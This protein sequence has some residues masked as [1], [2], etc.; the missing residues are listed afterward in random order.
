VEALRETQL[1]RLPFDL[2]DPTNQDALP[3]EYRFEGLD[4]HRRRALTAAVACI[5]TARLNR[6]ASFPPPTLMTNACELLRAAL[7]ADQTA[8]DAVVSDAVAAGAALADE[9]HKQ[10][11]L[12]GS[13]RLSV[14]EQQ[15]QT[16]VLSELGAQPR[17]SATLRLSKMRAVNVVPHGG[18]QVGERIDLCLVARALGPEVDP[19]SAVVATASAR[20]DTSTGEVSFGE[21]GELLILQ[22]DAEP[23]VIQFEFAFAGAD[24]ADMA[25]PRLGKAAKPM[26]W[27]P[28][29]QTKRTT[30]QIELDLKTADVASATKKAAVA[31]THGKA[32]LFGMAK[33]GA[34]A[35]RA[36]A[37]QMRRGSVELQFADDG[38]QK[39]VLDA[40][41]TQVAPGK[42]REEMI[43]AMLETRA[44]HG[45]VA[46]SQFMELC[47]ELEQQ[48]DCN[49]LE[50]WEQTL[51]ESTP[52]ASLVFDYSFDFLKLDAPAV[53][54]KN[55]RGDCAPDTGRW[56]FYD[57]NLLVFRALAHHLLPCNFHIT[58]QDSSALE[59][60][61]RAELNRLATML[62]LGEELLDDV[63]QSFSGNLA[64]SLRHLKQAEHE[65]AKRLR[66]ESDQIV[67][68]STL[69]AT[70]SDSD[71]LA[72]DHLAATNQIDAVDWLLEDFSLKYGVPVTYRKLTELLELVA[73]F[74]VSVPFL[75]RLKSTLQM[76][77]ANAD[78]LLPA[79]TKLL[80]AIKAHVSSSLL[81][82]LRSYQAFFDHK[83]PD[84]AALVA[85]TVSVLKKTAE[86][87]KWEQQLL[88]ALAQ[89]PLRL[90]HAMVT[91]GGQ[92]L[93]TLSADGLHWTP[94][95][96][97]LSAEKLTRICEAVQQD[98]E[99]N[100][101]EYRFLFEEQ[102]APIVEQSVKQ[103]AKCV[104]QL[105][106][107]F[108]D[109]A[110]S[111]EALLRSE[112]SMQLYMRMNNLLIFMREV[113]PSAAQDLAEMDTDLLF[114]SM[115]MGQI[116]QE[117]ALTQ[118]MCDR[119]IE[120]DNWEPLETSSYTVVAE[121][122]LHANFQ[123]T[124][125]AAKFSAPAWSKLP[126][127]HSGTLEKKGARDKDGYKSRWF[128]LR[129]HHLV[130]Y[131]GSEKQSIKGNINLLNA[132]AVEE[133]SNAENEL[134]IVMGDAVGR[135]FNLRADDPGTRDEWVSAVSSAWN[136]ASREL[137]QQ[138]S[139][140]QD[141]GVVPSGT[142]V[143][144]E[145]TRVDKYG[146]NH[147]RCASPW[148][149][150]LNVTALDGNRLLDPIPR[151]DGPFH[152]Q[153]AHDL[154]FMMVQRVHPLVARW[155]LPKVA[156]LVCQII[157]HYCGRMEE[158]CNAELT[159]LIGTHGRSEY[160]PQP[161]QTTG[162]ARFKTVA[163]VSAKVKKVKS[164][165]VLQPPS[166]WWV[167]LSNIHYLIDKG[168]MAFCEGIQG[169][170]DLMGAEEFEVFQEA[171]LVCREPC[172]HNLGHPLD[173][174]VD[175]HSDTMSTIITATL[176]GIPAIEPEQWWSG[177]LCF[178]DDVLDT[179][180][181]RTDEL[182]FRR[183]LRRCGDGFSRALEAVLVG[184]TPVS[185]V[186][187]LSDKLDLLQRCLQD[188]AEFFHAGGQGLSDH[189][190]DQKMSLHS[191]LG[192]LVSYHA[193]DNMMLIA[194]VQ[195]WSGHTLNEQEG[196]N[197]RLALL[198]LGTREAD[199][200]V[201]QFLAAE[202]QREREHSQTEEENRASGQ[203]ATP[204][205]KQLKLLWG[206]Q[207]NLEESVNTAR[208]ELAGSESQEVSSGFDAAA[209]QSA[210]SHLLPCLKAYLEGDDPLV[211]V[212][213]IARASGTDDLAPEEHVRQAAYTAMLTAIISSALRPRAGIHV[214][215]KNATVRDG[216]EKTS[217]E[218]GKLKKGQVIEVEEMHEQADGSVRAAYDVAGD[219]CW[220][221]A[222]KEDGQV[223]L[224]RVAP[225]ELTKADCTLL[226]RSL[227]SGRM[228]DKR[229][230]TLSR[231]MSVGTPDTDATPTPRL[232]SSNTVSVLATMVGIDPPI[233]VMWYVNVTDQAADPDDMWS[234]FT[235]T[236]CQK[237]ERAFNAKAKGLS[238]EGGTVRFQRSGEMTY[239]LKT[240]NLT[241]KHAKFDVA[242]WSKLPLL[243]SGTLEK[244]GARDK[245]GYKSRWF[246]LRGHHLVYYEDSESDKRNPKG[247]INLL[248]AAA[249][250]ESADT[251]NELHIVMGDAGG[252]TYRLKADSSDT[253]D[254]WVSAVSSA[255][256]DAVEE[257]QAL[258]ERALKRVSFVLPGM[259]SEGAEQRDWLQ[260][261][262]FMEATLASA[263]RVQHLEEQLHRLSTDRDPLYHKGSFPECVYEDWK[264]REMLRLDDQMSRLK[265][266]TA[267][268]PFC[269]R[270]AVRM[271][272]A[273][274]LK[275]KGGWPRDAFLTCRVVVHTPGARDGD[276]QVLETQARK[277]D[278]Q[279]GALAWQNEELAFT[280]TAEPMGIALEVYSVPGEMKQ[281]RR[282]S[283]TMA[284]PAGRQRSVTMAAPA[285]AGRPAGEGGGGAVGQQLVASV[286]LDLQQLAWCPYPH[287]RD[288]EVGMPCKNWQSL[289]S[290][291]QNPSVALLR[292]AL[293]YSFTRVN[294]VRHSVSLAR[295]ESH[296]AREI[297]CGQ[298]LDVAVEGMV[299][300]INPHEPGERAALRWLVEE[301]G[302]MTGLTLA[303][304]AVTRLN[305][306]MPH[307]TLNHLWLADVADAMEVLAANR[308][309]MLIAESELVEPIVEQL[310]DLVSTMFATF[311]ISFPAAV[312]EKDQLHGSGGGDGDASGSGGGGGGGSSLAAAVRLFLALIEMRGGGQA[313][314]QAELVACLEAHAERL[315]RSTSTALGSSSS[316][317]GGG[318][319]GSACSVCPKALNGL[320][321]AYLC[322]VIRNELSELPAYAGYMVSSWAC[323]GNV[324][325]AM[326]PAAA[327][328]WARPPSSSCFCFRCH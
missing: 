37:V 154:V 124:S 179:P 94:P 137:E 107:I 327:P 132:A 121:L 61:L 79:E 23:A 224:Q 98:V 26:L 250:E 78:A 212:S 248:N 286:A 156:S 113:A 256:E 100:D 162:R 305:R 222:T 128:E 289:G 1:P 300:A 141:L 11:F 36:K 60:E 50:V 16:S 3:D 265:S 282:R 111:D 202:L 299:A 210:E 292:L 83:A 176:A 123:H 208:G 182:L 175:L 55:I 231:T 313:D 235:F 284:A 290:F 117:Y 74:R 291:P 34:H 41:F 260:N 10:Q 178:L 115:L 12:G 89:N 293:Q 168:T 29:P 165:T 153:S 75:M 220:T 158:M 326:P 191:R 213:E 103:H 321:W 288:I 177:L 240:T 30:V 5:F 155:K 180:A 32:K 209:K 7:L 230:R 262:L 167:K 173:Q 169:I 304:R 206:T 45:M 188:V 46:L 15:R 245:D 266:R 80:T 43:E 242:V 249:V 151:E 232:A 196:S 116:E 181:E 70:T 189:I 221:T 195:T 13:S 28:T 71:S 301:Y 193:C 65:R 2:H 243:H 93:G 252:R 95:H 251:E 261:N 311:D 51:Q 166:E 44:K 239:T 223:L 68:R 316:S 140:D 125:K 96:E 257:Q 211:K 236:E 194:Q 297:P 271:H 4:E 314:P 171:V 58:S 48:Y 135:T 324:C 127:L 205:V 323:N 216:M 118:L 277:V 52:P 82:C 56:N 90:M 69:P 66:S 27:S 108:M 185:G 131:E 57:D 164:A 225:R 64:A 63:V 31:G 49:P 160:S 33:H 228:K 226:K 144:I 67:A 229:K 325:M 306:L 187:S 9:M 233:T 183:M 308:S 190:L 163:A 142:V 287:W 207:C 161:Q 6:L 219:R 273:A 253:Q 22:L 170:D 263:Q 278:R 86:P 110:K 25:A 18:W 152:S 122:A 54:W 203:L 114:R 109:A 120:A 14:A 309:L 129:G 42:P 294:P 280:L 217:K 214:V 91:K 199:P 134:H 149:G 274:H 138:N 275:P 76:V 307:A 133:S 192:S 81:R 255:R 35:A 112:S 102:E 143:D 39:A 101:T 227:L 319:D 92:P 145:E 24:V 40:F 72:F 328:C 215:A 88:H 139:D 159:A 53:D 318:D 38:R 184:D 20:V 19:E 197:R 259:S 172:K 270:L 241:A 99:L 247:D 283:V 130:Y 62:G 312:V 157:W 85:L 105:A 254:A 21:E 186:H 218:V 281:G 8:W 285:C 136:E 198:V 279:S 148:K 234:P 296:A 246:E 302:S 276:T 147:V 126:L 303:T 315:V 295:T 238:L 272:A 258:K 84:C 200:D 47:D 310:W 267:E 146:T 59:E 237:L 150:W 77:A 298:L 106:N 317:S 264:P 322:A 73:A 174:L 269:G 204:D 87:D 104:W 201:K 244:K 17:Y 97:A 119:M 268:F 320:Q